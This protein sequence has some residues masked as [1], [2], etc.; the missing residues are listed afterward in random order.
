MYLRD[1][2]CVC[3]RGMFFKFQYH[4]PYILHKFR[5]HLLLLLLLL[6][7]LF[8]CAS[9]P[10]NCIGASPA[11]YA[12][13][14]GHARCLY[15]LINT[16]KADIGQCADNSVTPLMTASQSG[17]VDIVKLLIQTGSDGKQLDKQASDGS[18]VFHMAAGK[19]IHDSRFDHETGIAQA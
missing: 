2:A 19:D 7:L 8:P 13:Q 14:K 6:L 4:F 11:F 10:I 18:T 17:H 12:C 5:D 1:C 15:Y 9:S 16:G 3:A